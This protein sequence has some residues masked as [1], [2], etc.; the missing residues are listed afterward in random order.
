MLFPEYKSCIAKFYASWVPILSTRLRGGTFLKG[1]C[2]P[3]T[4]NPRRGRRQQVGGS[5]SALCV[6]TRPNWRSTSC[7]EGNFRVPLRNVESQFRGQQQEVREDSKSEALNPRC[8]CQHGQTGDQQV[9]LRVPLSQQLSHNS[10]ANNRKFE[11]QID[12]THH[13]RY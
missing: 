1:P 5:Q 2:L 6:S 10:A 11:A 8:V 9:V 7:L 4:L 12:P 3:E 13:P